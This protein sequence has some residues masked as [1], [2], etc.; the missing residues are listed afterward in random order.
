MNYLV[1]IFAEEM[2]K[3]AKLK[4]A[5]C[6]H[7]YLLLFPSTSYP[8]LLPLPLPHPVLQVEPEIFF[9]LITFNSCTF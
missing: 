4:K 8:S 2:K 1:K 9:T 7:L 5:E 6:V 3:R